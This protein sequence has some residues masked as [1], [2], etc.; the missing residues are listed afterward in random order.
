MVCFIFWFSLV[1]VI[2]GIIIEFI[3]GCIVNYVILDIVVML[4]YL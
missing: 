3:C 4:E 2:V 1:R